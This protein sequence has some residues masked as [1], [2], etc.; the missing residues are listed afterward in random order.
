[1]YASGIPLVTPGNP[2]QAAIIGGQLKTS[3]GGTVQ[4]LATAN[5]GLSIEGS[6]GFWFWTVTVSVT[7]GGATTTDGW[8]F[9][10]PVSPASVDLYSTRNSPVSGALL[11]P[12]TTLGDMIYG[13]TAGTAARLP[14]TLGTTPTVLASTGNGGTASAPAWE[15]LTQL[16][17]GNGPYVPVAG[18]AMT[19]PLSP[20]VVALSQVSGT[21]AV[22]AAAGNA[23]GLT[24]SGSSWTIATPA[25]PVGDG[26]VIRFRFTQGAVAPPYPVVWG[27]G[28]DFGSGTFPTLST[29]AGKVD[30]IGYEYVASISRWCYV[31]SGLGN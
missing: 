9:F 19:G 10:L 29:V 18:T 14:G 25:N 24:L 6:T 27:S 16:G 8:Q 28:Y 7:A 21:V 3:G 20:G 15:T 5:A 31:G 13:G 26:Q 12:M 2:V 17:L 1:M 22:N 4:L 11:N 23:F 30:I